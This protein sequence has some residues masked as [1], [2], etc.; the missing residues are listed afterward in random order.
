MAVVGGVNLILHPRTHVSLSALNMLA[1]DGACKV[2]D[3][4]ADGFVPGEG[5]GAVLLKPL[6]DAERDGDEILPP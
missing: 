1:G 4:R 6:A 5:V 2:F 3:E